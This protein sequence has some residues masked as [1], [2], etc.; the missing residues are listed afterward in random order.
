MQQHGID[1]EALKKDENFQRDLANLEKEMRAKKS[2]DAGY[3][4]LGMK[5]AIEA[6]EEEI[7][8]IGTFLVNESFDRLAD[9][10]VEK[11]GFNLSDSEDLGTVRAIYE[12]GIP[13]YSERDLKGSKGDIFRF[14]TTINGVRNWN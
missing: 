5:L 9:R 1:I 6:K 8:E 13:R 10:L 7:N 2:I 4:L 11:R 12:H 14:L 3:K